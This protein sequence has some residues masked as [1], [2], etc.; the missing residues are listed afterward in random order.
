MD[1]FGYNGHFN[2]IN[3]SNPRAWIS[4]H[5]FQSSLISFI[6]ILWFSAY[7]SFTSLVR[8]IPKHFIIL[9]QFL[10][11]LFFYIP[12]WYFIVSVKKCNCF[13]YINLVSCYLAEFI[14]SIVFCVE[15]LG[16]SIYSIMW[17]AY[18]NNFN[19]SLPIWILFT[20]FSCLIAV[21]RT[22]NIML[23]RNGESG[24]YVLFQIL[25]GMLSVF[26]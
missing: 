8:F 5:F 13:L 3:S 26:H 18:F 22:S 23:N 12:F 16:F 10:N 21:A 24:Y 17:S 19:S 7:E 25:A 9:V 4:F 14:S 6:N 1:C 2:N 20:S 15:S 11:V